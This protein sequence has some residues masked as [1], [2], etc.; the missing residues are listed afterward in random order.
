M[1]K[2][3]FA[4]FAGQI[5]AFKTAQSRSRSIPGRTVYG[6]APAD[7]RTRRAS[8]RPDGASNQDNVGPLIYSPWIK[9]CNKAP[10]P[11]ARQVCFT[12]RHA[13]TETGMPAVA[14]AL[15]EPEGVP[16]KILRVTLPSKLQLQYGARIILD[17]EQPLASPFFTCFA[18]RLHG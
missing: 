5:D 13:R 15:I 11:N 17:Q 6:D 14:V 7:A 1:N 16:S 18:E 3:F 9:F 10:D 8:V 12:G 4:R 2:V